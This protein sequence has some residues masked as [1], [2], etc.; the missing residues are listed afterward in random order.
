MTLYALLYII[1]CP[2]GVVCLLDICAFFFFF[3]LFLAT[4]ETIALRFGTFS[5]PSYPT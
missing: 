1:Y 2:P 3:L 4:F 5:L